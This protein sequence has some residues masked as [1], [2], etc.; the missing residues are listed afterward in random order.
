M[1]SGITSN[2]LRQQEKKKLRFLRQTSGTNENLSFR[3]L[4]PFPAWLL[5][6]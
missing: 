5:D 4:W 2:P 3:L 1:K 6:L